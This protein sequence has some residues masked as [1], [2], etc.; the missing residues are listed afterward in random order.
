MKLKFLIVLVIT[1]AAISYFQS[2][3]TN[4]KLPYHCEGISPLSDKQQCWE[5]LIDSVLKKRGVDAALTVIADLYS[6]EPQ[7]ASDCHGYTHELG[8]AAYQLFSEHKDFKLSAKTSFCGFGFYH[9]FMEK[10]L[11]TTNDLTQAREF[12]NYAGRQTNQ[13]ELTRLSCFHGIGHGLLEDIPNPYLKGDDKAIIK[14]PLSICENAGKTDAEKN[15]CASG[16]FN[17]IAIYY[18]NPESGLQAKEDDPY[19]ICK[20]QTKT[21]FGEPCFDQMNTYVLFKLSQG[22]LLAAAKFAEKIAENNFANAAMHG[23]AGAYGQS[24]VSKIDY[25]KAI[26]ICKKVQSR[27]KSACLEGVLMGLLEGG[28][29]DSEY[30]EG[31][32]FCANGLL[33]QAEKDFCFNLLT[34][35]TNILYPEKQSAIC[36]NLQQQYQYTCTDI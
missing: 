16:V 28:Q 24:N 21:Y 7:F 5:N 14:T 8:E 10:L 33:D 1:I 26:K 4:A 22:D 3:N 34:W 29:P 19:L 32:K 9:A 18:A 2:R 35:N 36:K 15:R 25:A 13:N 31:I 11:R 27:L 20:S 6:E 23:L 12:C 17:V 30:L